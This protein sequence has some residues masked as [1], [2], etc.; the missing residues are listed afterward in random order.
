MLR[1]SECGRYIKA[2]NKGSD[3]LSLISAVRAQK[4][5][6]PEDL[7]HGYRRQP[8]AGRKK[9]L[10]DRLSQLH[11]GYG[12]RPDLQRSLQ[13]LYRRAPAA[14]PVEHIRRKTVLDGTAAG[15]DRILSDL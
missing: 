11:S 12:A 3:R 13:E 9:H 10:H 4:P 2:H 14:A 6:E 15:T 5:A 1:R 8:R 7:R